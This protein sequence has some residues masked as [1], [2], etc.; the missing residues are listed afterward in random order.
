MSITI[1]NDPRVETLVT[2]AANCCYDCCTAS[3]TEAMRAVNTNRAQIG[4]L[5]YTVN[6]ITRELCAGL[7]LSSV[8]RK[9]DVDLPGAGY[10]S[11]AVELG[12]LAPEA[13]KAA[14][15]MFWD[16]QVQALFEMYGSDEQLDQLYLRY[17]RMTRN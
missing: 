6:L 17:L 7:L 13:D 11:C 2:F 12:A 14:Q 4:H 5:L 16:S 1:G 3:Y 8:V 9:K 15:R 10:F